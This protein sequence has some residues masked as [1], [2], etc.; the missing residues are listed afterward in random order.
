MSNKSSLCVAAILLGAFRNPKVRWI[1]VGVAFLGLGLS[2]SYL[3][4]SILLLPVAVGTL[5]SALVGA[6]LRF[7]VLDAWVFPKLK[8]QGLLWRRFWKY[9]VTHATAYA[10]GWALINGLVLFGINYLVATLIATGVTTGF[11]MLSHFQWVWKRNL[12]T[13][14]NPGAAPNVTT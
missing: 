11:S 4:V 5:V 10:G 3:M 8:N 13:E 12:I 14:K 7:F 9:Q 1:I 6:I 2:I